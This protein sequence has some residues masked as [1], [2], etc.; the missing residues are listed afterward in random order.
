MSESKLRKKLSSQVVTCQRCSKQ[1][2]V[3]IKPGKRLSVEC[4]GC[5]LEFIISFKNPFYEVFQ[6]DPRLGLQGNLTR[7]VHRYGQL[8]DNVRVKFMALL[9]LF[10]LFLLILLGGLVFAFS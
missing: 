4:A 10:V 2:R 5:G 1:L 9:S 6:F 3:P 8:P 7:S